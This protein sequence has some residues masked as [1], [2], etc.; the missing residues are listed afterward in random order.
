MNNL[1]IEKCVKKKTIILINSLVCEET[2][3]K[4][5]CDNTHLDDSILISKFLSLQRSAY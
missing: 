4:F 1:I 3:P 5:A 2:R